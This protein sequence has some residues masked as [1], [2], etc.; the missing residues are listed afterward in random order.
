MRSL[1][2]L[3][4]ISLVLLGIAIAAFV[5]AVRRGQ[6]DDMDTPALDILVDDDGRDEAGHLRGARPTDA[7]PPPQDRPRAD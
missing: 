3:V 4:P 7:P 2:L 1:L 6:F 5:W